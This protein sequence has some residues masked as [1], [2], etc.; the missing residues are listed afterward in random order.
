MGN[1]PT[2]ITTEHIEHLDYI[3]DRV[4]AVTHEVQRLIE[5]TKKS[6][7]LTILDGIAVGIGMF[8]ALPIMLVLIGLLLTVFGI[9]LGSFFHH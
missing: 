6:S 7:R 5:V 1:A 3:S 2:D 8:I 4:D 9:S